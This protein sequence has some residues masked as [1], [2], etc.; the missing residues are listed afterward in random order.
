[1]SDLLGSLSVSS[2][3]LLGGCG[4]GPTG[5][6]SD[7]SGTNSAD[8][9]GTGDSEDTADSAPDTGDTGTAVRTAPT[10]VVVV[11]DTARYQLFDEGTMPRLYARR[12][13]GL[14]VEVVAGV[15]GWTLPT[16]TA[17]MSSVRMET[18]GVNPDDHSLPDG[19][20]TTVAQVL[21]DEGWATILDSSN[22]VVST[23][24]KAG[25]A[26]EVP[27]DYSWGLAEVGDEVLG[28][29]DAVPVDQPRFAWIQVMNLHVP[30]DKLDAS[31]EAAAVAADDA[32]PVDVIHPPK[33]DGYDGGAFDGLSD[34]DHAACAYAVET[35]QRCAATRADVEL[36]ELLDQLPPDAL[37]VVTAD[38]GEGWLDPNVE[39]NW[40][41][42]V[43]LTRNFMLLLHPTLAGQTVRLASEL[44]LTPTILDF[45]G[46]RRSDLP[47]E[48]VVLGQPRSAPPT[49]WHCDGHGHSEV[50]AWDESY[51]VIRTFRGAAK[52]VTWQVYE[53]ATDAGGDVDLGGTV[54]PPQPLMDAAEAWYT[55]NASLCP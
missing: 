19:S 16:T 8:S 34:V 29:L 2:L 43:K 14:Y 17:L 15:E 18:L 23:N 21:A 3:L 46:I 36:D 25:Y 39:H 12:G 26:V 49:T 52:P 48:G 1:M 11:L 50:A 38:H 13:D 40:G 35:A 22:G 55:Q 42:S 44:D 20:V 5:D 31:C 10:V 7:H 28:L 27:H 37:V 47:F 32:C 24:L 54:A 51:Q 6:P 45:L 9:G 30:Y 41:A 53:L 33:D 4:G